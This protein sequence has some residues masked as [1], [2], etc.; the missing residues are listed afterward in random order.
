[1][2]NNEILKIENLKKI[3]SNTTEPVL[4]GI[5]LSIYEG[6]YNDI[7]DCFMVII[8]AGANQEKGESRLDLI[9]KNL[10]EL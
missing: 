6:D 3:Y 2:S 5:D 4:K 1:M 8:T 10:N 9:D 7:N